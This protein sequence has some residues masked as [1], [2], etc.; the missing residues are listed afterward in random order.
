MTKTEY[1]STRKACYKCLKRHKENDFDLPAMYETIE[2]FQLGNQ[3]FEVHIYSNV[4]VL[5]EI[6]Q[7]DDVTERKV[8]IIH[9]IRFDPENPE[10]IVWIV[11]LILGNRIYDSEKKE[12]SNE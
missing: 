1:E 7:L 10:F 11:C 5:Q 3:T 6:V 8:P 2:R 9:G 12:N 4:I